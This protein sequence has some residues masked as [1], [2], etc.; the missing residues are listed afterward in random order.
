MRPL[1][2]RCTLLALGLLLAVPC[3]AVPAEPDLSDDPG[4]GLAAL[5]DDDIIID[6]RTVN[7]T[8]AIGTAAV[9]RLFPDLHVALCSNYLSDQVAT[10]IENDAPLFL[11]PDDP[12]MVGFSDTWGTLT[13][14]EYLL[15]PLDGLGDPVA[16]VHAEFQGYLDA[17]NIAIGGG[18][19]M[20]VSPDHYWGFLS[21]ALYGGVLEDTSGHTTIVVGESWTA[22]YELNATI[23]IPA[24]AFVIPE[25]A[26]L[27]LV[28]VGGLALLSRRREAPRSR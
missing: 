6:H 1:I 14:L 25:P 28:A 19:T 11:G 2:A 10:S 5:Q 27:A 22:F 23:T 18:A 20:A 12:R 26:T 8:M 16:A 3:G 4:G 24:D 7:S 17:I 15:G 9:N 21:H 13:N